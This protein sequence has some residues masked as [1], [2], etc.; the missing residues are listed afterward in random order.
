MEA[1]PKRFTGADA[2]LSYRARS[3][4]GWTPEGQA[5]Y[6]RAWPQRHPVR[7]LPGAGRWAAQMRQLDCPMIFNHD[8]WGAEFVLQESAPSAPGSALVQP[9]V[10]CAGTRN[11]PPAHPSRPIQH[12]FA[13]MS[14]KAL[15]Q[16]CEPYPGRGQTAMFCRSFVFRDLIQHLT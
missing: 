16:N 9:S 13:V 4:S 5:S 6:L 10:R 7:L 1:P 15:S 3:R 12:D 8:N 11:R 14:H 2:D